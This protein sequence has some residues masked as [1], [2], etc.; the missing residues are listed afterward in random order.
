VA[1]VAAGALGFGTAIFKWTRNGGVSRDSAMLASW[2][3]SIFDSMTLIVFAL[4]SAVEL[5]ALH[6]LSRAT[7]IA[8]VTVVTVLSGVIV[9]VFVLL[10]R[11]DWL[12]AA[13]HFVT[14]VL[15]RMPMFGDNTLLI[16]AAERASTVWSSLRGTG[17]IRPAMSSVCVVTFDLLCLHFVFVA[18][19][20]HLHL[21]VL[22]AGYGVPLLLGRASF[23]PGGIAVIEVAMSALYGGLGVPANAAIVS[24]LVYRLISFWLP[25]VS[26]IP[27]AIALQSRK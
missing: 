17:W 3:P 23:L 8:L 2:L 6:Q 1:I 25:A 16:D 12:L 13:A 14:R 22:I 5:L 26:G 9:T 24:V 11:N 10:A 18:A 7:V 15:S 4:L 20:Q 19:G 21:S 27:V